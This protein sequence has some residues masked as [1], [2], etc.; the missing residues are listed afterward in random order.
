M[1]AE[2]IVRALA[3][4]PYPTGDEGYDDCAFCESRHY[5]EQQN[6]IHAEDCVW[7]LARE[8]VA[9]HP[10]G[11][12]H[13]SATTITNVVLASASAPLFEDDEG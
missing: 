1:D 12:T 5:D 13:M 10:T 11:I 6:L 8:W 3:A 2:Q 9:E 7:R 4:E